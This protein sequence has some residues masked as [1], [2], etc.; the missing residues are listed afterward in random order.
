MQR[1]HSKFGRATNTAGCS[2]AWALTKCLG[3]AE[4]VR[5]LVFLIAI[6]EILAVEQIEKLCIQPQFRPFRDLKVLGGA[7][8]HLNE[9]FTIKRIWLNHGAARGNDNVR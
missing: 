4:S 9:R 3:R 7:Q 2:I 1:F 5:V 6:A 8:I